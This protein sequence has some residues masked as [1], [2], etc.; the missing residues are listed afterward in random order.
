[1]KKIIYLCFGL[2]CLMGITSVSA[3]NFGDCVANDSVVCVSDVGLT[4]KK[5][6][7]EIN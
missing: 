2:I 5:L 7:M 4:F 6:L 3:V 1:M